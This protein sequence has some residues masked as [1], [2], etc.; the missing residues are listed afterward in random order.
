MNARFS[1]TRSHSYTLLHLK[2]PDSTTEGSDVGHCAVPLQQL[3]QF[4]EFCSMA[5]LRS[6]LKG[7]SVCHWFPPFTG[8]EIPHQRAVFKLLFFRLIHE[9]MTKGHCVF[10]YDS[11]KFTLAFS[12]PFLSCIVCLVSTVFVLNVILHLGWQMP[13]TTWKLIRATAIIWS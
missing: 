10:L 4:N 2:V 3:A 12:L 13:C 1:F 11:S 5:F 8:P 9:R 6:L 7:S